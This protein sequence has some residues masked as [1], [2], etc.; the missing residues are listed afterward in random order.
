MKIVKKFSIPF[1]ILLELLPNASLFNG[2]KVLNP[3]HWLLTQSAVQEIYINR[4]SK[5]R[6]AVIE[7]RKSL[8][9]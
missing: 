3:T 7:M 8:D 6:Q 5:M 2:L 9:E 1:A 4:C